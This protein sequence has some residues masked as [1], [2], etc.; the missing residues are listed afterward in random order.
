MHASYAGWP[1]EDA[2]R[3]AHNTFLEVAAT[4]GALGLAALLTT[5]VSSGAAARRMLE[6]PSPGE[7]AAVGAVLLGLLASITAHAC[8]DHLLGFTA[9]YLLFGILVG[10][11]AGVR[12]TATS[13]SAGS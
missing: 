12:A 4:S 10:A 3:S 9:H 2:V 1:F 13:P 11:A 6:Q 7:A 5:L 8:V